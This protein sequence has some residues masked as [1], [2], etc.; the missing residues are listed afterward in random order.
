MNKFRPWLLE[1]LKN[2]SWRRVDFAQRAGLS[3]ASLSDVLNGIYRPGPD[4]C[5]AIAQAL[6]EPPEKVFRLAGL[7][8]PLPAGA[9]ELLHELLET[10][11]RL[12]PEKRQE[13]LDYALWQ[14][15]R[16]QEEP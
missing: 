14:L 4:M 8:P 3:M 10:F 15:R 9:D 7:L 13:V 5:Q 2:R 11:Q 12:T 1:E 6:G 16:Q